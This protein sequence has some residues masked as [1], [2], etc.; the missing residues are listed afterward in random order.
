[1]LDLLTSLLFGYYYTLGW[2]LQRLGTLVPQLQSNCFLG[3]LYEGDDPVA[4]VQKIVDNHPILHF[5]AN[6]LFA[7]A[8]LTGIVFGCYI[9]N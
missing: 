3:I 9:V 6:V 7:T 1:M 4:F 2:L 5:V 8:I